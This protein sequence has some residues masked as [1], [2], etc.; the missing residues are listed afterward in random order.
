MK[1]IILIFRVIIVAFLLNAFAIAS[2]LLNLQDLQE[3]NFT[4]ESAL[5]NK[6]AKDW[7]GREDDVY[8]YKE[9]PYTIMYMLGEC[10]IKGLRL[11]L[12]D[13]GKRG[14][15]SM[16]ASGG[17]IFLIAAIESAKVESVKFLLENKLTYKDNVA[18]YEGWTIDE[19][20]HDENYVKRTPL[21]F[22][23][24]KLIEAKFIDDSNA[25]Q[26][27]EKIIEILEKY[28]IER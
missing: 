25:V 27:Y 2:N 26:N 12:D 7:K 8:F 23:T 1:N 9:T 10:D 15:I 3:C 19:V 11:M 24:Q 6:W 16:Q 5:Y 21:Q 4:R 22:A 14:F 13:L 17:M 28:K 18:E 20:Y